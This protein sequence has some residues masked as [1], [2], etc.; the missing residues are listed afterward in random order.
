[1]T[2][3]TRIAVVDDHPVVR[4]GIAQ[5]FAEEGDFEIVGE[6]ACADDAVRMARE[7]KPDV[8]VLDVTMPGDG[9]EAAAKIHAYQ[10]TTKILMLSIREEL[11][12]VRSALK[13]GALG[14]VS[15]GI[16]GDEL[17]AA[18]RKLQAGA[19]YIG[20]E[21]AARLIA[22]DEE[23]PARQRT[24]SAAHPQLTAREAEI[25]ELLGEGLSNQEIAER[26]GLSENTVKHYLTP[27]LQKL[28]V[29]NRT[30]AALLKRKAAT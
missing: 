12:V 5:T 4:K 18:V 8:M 3:R 21:L 7:L 17:V 30:A 1:M 16:D 15:K 25:L 20:P 14:Y 2:R 11:S 13:A 26:I 9:V 29:R 10:P 6:G 28:G 23:M 19:R 22:G 24:G 27:L